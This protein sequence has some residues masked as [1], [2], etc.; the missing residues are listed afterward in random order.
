VRSLAEDRDGGIWAGGMARLCHG[1]ADGP[2]SCWG[3]GNGLP[4][5]AILSVLADREGTLWLGLNGSGL[6]QWVGQPWT[7]RTRWPG[8]P[9]SQGLDVTSLAATSDGGLLASVFGRGILHWDGRALTA[10][11]PADGLTED[12]RTVVEPAPGVV[13]A[14]A[15]HG[16]FERERAG[17]FRRTLPLA[18][19]FASGFARDPDGR[20]HVFTEDQGVFRRARTGAWERAPDIDALASGRRVSGL[21][22][23]ESGDLWITTPRELVVRSAAG[24]LTRHALGL[25]NGLTDTVATVLPFGADEVWVGGSGGLAV[26]KGGQWRV[27][28]ET[29][30]VPGNVYFLRRGPDG[31][32]WAG[33]SRGIARVRDG[34][35]T[36]WDHTSGLVG[37]ECNGGA[38][39]LAD[40]SLLA[41][42]SGSLARFDAATPVHPAPPLAVHWRAPEDAVGTA[43]LRR[44]AGARRLVLGWSAPWLAP[45]P[46]EY[47]TRIGDGAWSAATRAAEMT[48]E[49]LPAGASDVAVRA[50][51]GPADAWSAPA[52]LRVTV[53]PHPWETTGARIA[54]VL[55]VGGLMLAGA[56]WNARRRH[57]RREHALTR[58]R[59]DFM[60]SASHE[61]RTP[62][63]QIRLFGDMLRLGRTRTEGERTDALQTI[64]RAT[65]RLE[66]IASNLMRL[67]RGEAR[68]I[69]PEPRR[70]SMEGLVR[71]LATELAPFAEARGVAL[72]VD[73]EPG[74]AGVVDPD[75]LRVA[76]ANLVE[77]A[78]K[79]G[80][81]GQ[82]VRVEAER[83]ADGLRVVVEDEGPGIPAEDRERVWERFARLD[84]DRNSAVGGTG[85]GLAVVREAV[86]QMGGTA[87]I[88]DAAPSGTR[89]VLWLPQPEVEG[90]PAPAARPGATP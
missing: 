6:L 83:V 11:G 26:G 76:I 59:T 55:A 4:N 71:D 70:T 45:D 9:T 3:V 30:G 54:L 17:R 18:D 66:A 48:I 41:A 14:A 21:T 10:W 65:L 84:R 72:Q 57:A 78:L 38:L 31:A 39:V 90:D 25:E 50:R 5:T 56:P 47:Q 89:V 49:S 58:M 81:S 77:N 75:G 44:P 33:G 86:E 64:H 29:D 60:A 34:R 53:A 69:A 20:W 27:I 85:L 68:P 35:W 22:W 36:R 40:G 73:V 12:V 51:R 80:P 79:Y 63:A 74:L 16:V 87:R 8:D 13:W 15:R 19:G 37:D 88:E 23:T 24:S 7:H 82:V 32:I 28:P 43:V 1:T 62:I 2:W 61:L 67:A 52:S 46:I 42:T